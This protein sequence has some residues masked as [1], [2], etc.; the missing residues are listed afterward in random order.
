MEWKSY[1][2]LVL[3]F[4]WCLIKLLKEKSEYDILRRQ[5]IIKALDEAIDILDEEGYLDK[6]Y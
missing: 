4:R 6:K 2:S 1:K 3:M 5:D